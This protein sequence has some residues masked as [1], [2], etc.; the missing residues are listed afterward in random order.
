MRTPEHV[1]DVFLRPGELFFGDRQTRIRTVLGSCV[2]LVLWH[3][4]RCVGGMCHFMLPSRGR[5]GP[6]RGKALDGRYADEAMAMLTREIDLLGAPRHEYQAKVFGGG[7]MFSETGKPG[8]VRVGLRNV[9]AVRELIA[10]NGFEI[11]VEHLGGTGHRHVIFDVWSGAVWMKHVE[12]PVA[13]PQQPADRG[14]ADG[15]ADPC[16]ALGSPA[17]QGL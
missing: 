14:H 1:F 2:S 16:G 7:D 12:R 15:L 5:P 6:A 9:R 8:A 10:E 4:G 11:A 13:I 3:P 17:Q